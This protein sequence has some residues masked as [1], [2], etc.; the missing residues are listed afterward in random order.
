MRELDVV[1]NV[2]GH[3]SG[4]LVVDPGKRVVIAHGKR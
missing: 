2:L 1:G 3:V 4:P